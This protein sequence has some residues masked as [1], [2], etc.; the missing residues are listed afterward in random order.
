MKLEEAI[1]EYIQYLIIEKGASKNTTSAYMNDLISFK[2]Y[3]FINSINNNIEDIKKEHIVNYIKSLY[4]K[5][6]VSTISRRIVTLRNFYK[7]L[8]KEEICFENVMQDI[9]LPKRNKYLPKILSENE[10][11]QI[12]ESIPVDTPSSLR[13]RLII[14]LLYATGIR[15]SELCNLKLSQINIKMKFIKVIGKGNKERFVPITKYVAS[16]LDEYILNN[17]DKLLIDFSINECFI[18]DVGK[19][20]DRFQCNVILKN[21]IKNSGV[22][23]HC[24]PHTLRHTFATHMLENNADLRSIQEMLGHSD[25]STTTIYTHITNDKIN[26]EYKMYHPRQGKRDF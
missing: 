17:R 21:I 24:T 14:E 16:L 3:C 15:I 12:L 6:S 11:K 9:E 4:S 7:F 5:V 23:K 19:P 1:D 8:I 26:K 10:I 22:E 25:I 20:L 13:N 2:K 18:S